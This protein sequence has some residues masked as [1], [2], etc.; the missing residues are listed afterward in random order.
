MGRDLAAREAVV[1]A[2]V[3]AGQMAKTATPAVHTSLEV[4]AAMAV[5][6]RGP[7]SAEYIPFH[8]PVRVRYVLFGPE[9]LASS[10]QLM[11]APQKVNKEIRCT[12]LF[13]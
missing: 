10:H 5:V 1:A 3:V 12:F 13:K 9:I 6:G 2:A 11:F 8:T 7:T 4:A